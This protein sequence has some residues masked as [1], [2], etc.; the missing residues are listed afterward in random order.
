MA[1]KK[2][3][4]EALR[5]QPAPAGHG[6][7]L[8]RARR[9]RGRAGPAR[10]HH[11]RRPRARRAADRR[12]RDRRRCSRRATHEDWNKVGPGRDPRGRRRPTSSSRS[13]E[14]ARRCIPVINITSAQLILG[15]DVEPTLRRRRRSSR[16]QTPGDAIGILGA[17]QTLPRP[18]QLHRDRLDGVHRRPASGSRSTSPS[19]PTGRAAPRTRGVVV[20]SD[21]AATG[22]RHLEQPRGRAASA[23]TATRLPK[24][25]RDSLLRRPRPRGQQRARRSGARGVAAAVPGG[26]ELG[27]DGFGLEARPASGRAGA[28]PRRGAGRRLRRATATGEPLVIDPDG[29]C[30]LNAFALAVSRTRRSPARSPPTQLEAE[31]PAAVRPRRTYTDATGRTTR[32]SR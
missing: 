13:E 26:G 19:E 22:D 15:A 18:T 20:E 1:T 16:T 5:V 27:P 29:R 4:V 32:S 30:A 17:P 10:P 12:R 3:L 6:V 24:T 23:P 28:A 31:L 7:R 9:P 21:G 25:R 11:R 2:D 14:H 8:R